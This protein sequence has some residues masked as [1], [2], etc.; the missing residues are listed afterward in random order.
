M[1]LA[2]LSGHPDLIV[3]DEVG[4]LEMQGMGWNSLLRELAAIETIPQVWIV[5]DELV[6]AV[7]ERWWIP[8]VNLV[9]ADRRMGTKARERSF[10]QLMENIVNFKPG[11]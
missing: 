2:S 6:D 3:I 7:M 11:Q 8:A 5:R 9:A 1:V 10:K 4:R